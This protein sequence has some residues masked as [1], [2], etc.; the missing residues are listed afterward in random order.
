MDTTNRKLLNWSLK[1]LLVFTIS[2]GIPSITGPNQ[3]K[4]FGYLNL[5]VV[6]FSLIINA[7]SSYHFLVKKVI[8]LTK[9]EF[10]EGELPGQILNLAFFLSISALA[11]GVPFLFSLKFYMNKTQN[12]WICFERVEENLALSPSFYKKSRKLCILSILVPILVIFL[13]VLKSDSLMVRFLLLSAGIG[14]VLL[15]NSAKF[16]KFSLCNVQYFRVIRY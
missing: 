16:R 12:L 1:P 8:F 9:F 2:C 3:H 4:L 15:C 10:W 11:F 14:H 13:Y 6:S 5:V 7:I